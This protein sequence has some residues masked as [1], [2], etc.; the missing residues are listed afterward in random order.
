MVEHLCYPLHKNPPINN[1]PLY[2]KIN[3]HKDITVPE[4]VH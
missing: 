1:L 4:L 3:D 2:G